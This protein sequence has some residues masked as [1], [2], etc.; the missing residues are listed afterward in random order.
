M[1]AVCISFRCACAG[2]YATWSVI[3]DLQDGLLFPFFL[4]VALR[5]GSFSL[6]ISQLNPKSLNH[7]L[8]IMPL[9]QSHHLI[10]S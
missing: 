4:I 1:F 2:V 3:P 6:L 7:Y 9:V 8:F 10:A 5:E